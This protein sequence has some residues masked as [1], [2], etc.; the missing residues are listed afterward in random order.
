MS[1]R[2]AYV[3]QQWHTIL[4]ILNDGMFWKVLSLS[5]RLFS[6]KRWAYTEVF[7][8]LSC[9]PQC[10]INLKIMNCTTNREFHITYFNMTFSKII[11]ATKLA[12]KR[13]TCS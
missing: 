4:D 13:N 1:F 12:A 9:L 11:S 3:S 6:F 7:K 5:N 10:I 2:I 8:T